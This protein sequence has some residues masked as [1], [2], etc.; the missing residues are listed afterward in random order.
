MTCFTTR[1]ILKLTLLVLQ[2]TNVG[3]GALYGPVIPHTPPAS[4]H[5]TFVNAFKCTTLLKPVRSGQYLEFKP[6]RHW[7]VK[8]KS[9]PKFMYVNIRI[10]AET[11]AL[12]WALLWNFPLRKIT[13]IHKTL[14]HH[15]ACHLLV[16]IVL[17]FCLKHK[18]MKNKQI[19][20]F[21]QSPSWEV[22]SSSVRQEIPW[23]LYNL[24][25][26]YCI[27]NSLPLVLILS[28][29]IRLNDPHTISWRLF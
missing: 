16:Q 10:M 28:Q 6:L 13:T 29:I 8:R 21:E 15:V 25:V 27:D 26:H 23:I 17:T 5:R 4:V 18:S 3:V 22:D 20:T 1:I 2:N 12:P 9:I 19:T 24:T 14:Q 11:R 7:R